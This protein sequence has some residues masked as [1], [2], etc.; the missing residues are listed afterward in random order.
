SRKILCLDD[1]DRQ[2]ALLRECSK[3]LSDGSPILHVSDL[4]AESQST[5][6]GMLLDLGAVPDTKSAA[7]LPNLTLFGGLEVSAGLHLGDQ[8]ASFFTPP[9]VRHEEFAQAANTL[10]KDNGLT[11]SLGEYA[12]EKLEA[13]PVHRTAPLLE[14]VFSQGVET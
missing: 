12:A 14:F 6:R 4:S 10:P 2:T 1:A 8:T 7:M 13:V 5:I 3:I 11:E 9:N